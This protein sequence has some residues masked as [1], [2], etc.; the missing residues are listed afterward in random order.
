[1]ISTP[2]IPSTTISGLLLAVNEVPPRKRKLEPAAGSPEGRITFNPATF[3]CK[4][5]SVEEIVPFT[6]S[7]AL[8]VEI[9]PVRS[10]FF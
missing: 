8:T 4:T 9:A 10:D 2:A 5:C 1:M 7:S 3:P 6:K